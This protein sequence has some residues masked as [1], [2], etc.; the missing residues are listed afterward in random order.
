MQT[1]EQSY[2]D[3]LRTREWRTARAL[4]LKRANGICEACLIRE[5]TEVHHETYDYGRLPPLYMLKA[6]CKE[7]H[8]IVT[9][10]TKFELWNETETASLPWVCPRA[11]KAA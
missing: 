6:I 4:V 7:C 9:T 5:A 3:F 8:G 1:A 11:R 2:A 10:L